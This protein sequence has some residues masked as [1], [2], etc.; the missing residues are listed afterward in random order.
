MNLPTEDADL[1][2]K[3]M[4]RLQFYVNRKHQILPNVASVEDYEGL[5]S[6]TIASSLP[7]NPSWPNRRGNPKSRPRIGGQMWMI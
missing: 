5:P 7:W 1:Y 2:Y 4:W 3:L 6:K